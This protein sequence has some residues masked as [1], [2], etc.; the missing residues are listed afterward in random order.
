M[1]DTHVTIVGNVVDEPK[2]RRTESGIPI[3][4]FRIASSSRRFDKQEGRW[5]D[6]DRLFANVTCWRGTAQNV[7]ESL[8]KGQPVI[9][10]GRLYC[11]EY[12]VD[13][14][15]KVSYQLDAD[16]VGH[17]LSRGTSSFSKVARPLA[18]TSVDADPDGMPADPSDSFYPFE[19]EPAELA[20]AV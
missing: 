1:N 10:V 5:V 20:P 2:S 16:A 8:R 7:A 12:T 6:G 15:P 3:T 17:D 4:T 18:I 11:R 19:A 9:A 14:T 13:E